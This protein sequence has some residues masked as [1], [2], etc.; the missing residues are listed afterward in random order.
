MKI[1]RIMTIMLVLMI[2]FTAV[3][4]C[5]AFET[6]GSMSGIETFL[7]V[8][9]A[10]GGFLAKITGSYDVLENISLLPNFARTWSDLIESDGISPGGFLK[11]ILR[12]LIIILTPIQTEEP[13]S[14]SYSL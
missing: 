10:W 14:E 4:P 7:S 13:Q 12:G 9:K 3:A 8:L 1:K 5:F 11:S 6:E 2:A